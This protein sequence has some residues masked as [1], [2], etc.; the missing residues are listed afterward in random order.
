MKDPVTVEAWILENDQI[1]V[2]MEFLD[3]AMVVEA[4]EMVAEV[5]EM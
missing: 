1:M 5:K 2:E 3:Q 4:T